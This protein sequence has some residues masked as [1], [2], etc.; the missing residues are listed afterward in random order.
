MT[1]IP[2]IHLVY[3]FVYIIAPERKNRA[4]I[5]FSYSPLATTLQSPNKACTFRWK[6]KKKTSPSE[7]HSSIVDLTKNFGLILMQVV[8]S[9]PKI[10][11]TLDQIFW[12]YFGVGDIIEFVSIDQFHGPTNWKF[13]VL[14]VIL[15]ADWKVVFEKGD[16]LRRVVYLIKKDK[17]RRAVFVLSIDKIQ[18]GNVRGQLWRADLSKFLKVFETEKMHFTYQ[19]LRC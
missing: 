13:A 12:I 6:K 4:C 1:R 2:P 19:W 16:G 18:I 3:I 9:S 14:S 15:F 17:K 5:I 10:N 7:P 8:L 11:S